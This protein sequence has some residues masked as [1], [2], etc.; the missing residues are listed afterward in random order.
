MSS[1]TQN[2]AFSAILFLYRHVL[3][4]E[5]GLLENVTKAK[6]PVKLPVVFTREE[7]R[8]LL[9]KFEG[10]KWLMAN[11]LYGTG[12]SCMNTSAFG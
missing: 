4:L 2:Q 5:L 3:K 7:D 1:S 10:S 12:L 6:K 9:T 11:L 8:S